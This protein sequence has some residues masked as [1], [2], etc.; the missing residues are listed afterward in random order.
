MKLTSKYVVEISIREEVTQEYLS[1][2]KEF[3]EEDTAF[4]M[5]NLRGKLECELRDH[6]GGV[7]KVKSQVITSDLG[8]LKW[9]EVNET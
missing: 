3:Y 6:F 4:N 1:Q 8:V 9:S 7:A 5:L 2:A